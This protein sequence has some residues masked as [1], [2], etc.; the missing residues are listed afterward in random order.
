[1]TT[2]PRARVRDR[3]QQLMVELRERPRL[4]LDAAVVR[5]I[6]EFGVACYEAGLQDREMGN[7]LPAP[8]RENDHEPVTG[9]YSLQGTDKEDVL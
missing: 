6:R 7:T 3:F 1:M 8:K 4:L 9:A 5:K 2:T